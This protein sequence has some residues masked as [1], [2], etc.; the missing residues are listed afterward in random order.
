[1]VVCGGQHCSGRSAL[2]GAVFLEWAQE[3]W[4]P[5]ASMSRCLEGNAK[6][7]VVVWISW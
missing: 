1:M 5:G 6:Q 2:W 7:H 4:K 3:T